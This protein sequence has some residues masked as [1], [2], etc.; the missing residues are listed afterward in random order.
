[1]HEQKNLFLAIGL[2]I[3]III[4]FQFLLPQQTVVTPSS[5]QTTKQDQQ[6]PSTDEQ[7]QVQNI[8]T[9][10]ESDLLSESIDKSNILSNLDEKVEKVNS[11]GRII[12]NRWLDLI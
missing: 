3:L 7:Q 1:M 10:F 11:N 5:Q 8:T 2:S 6:A 12:F 4:A 9:K